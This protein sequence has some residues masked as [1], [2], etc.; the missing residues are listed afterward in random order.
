MPISPILLLIQGRRDKQKREWAAQK[1]YF[2][3]NA[4]ILDTIALS[5]QPHIMS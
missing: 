4:Q 2:L 3:A 1:L 5:N